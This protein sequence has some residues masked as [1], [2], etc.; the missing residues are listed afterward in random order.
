MFAVLKFQFASNTSVLNLL[1]FFNFLRRAY[2][3]NKWSSIAASRS[4]TN[5]DSIILLIYSS[6]TCLRHSYVV[7]WTG[8]RRW[9]IAGGLCCHVTSQV[10]W[11]E[12]CGAAS[13]YLRGMFTMLPGTCWPACCL[14]RRQHCSSSSSSSRLW[15]SWSY[16]CHR[17]SLWVWSSVDWGVYVFLPPLS[18][19]VQDFLFSLR[20]CLPRHHQPTLCI[21]V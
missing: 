7:C 14:G 16:P 13:M 15:L 12:V 20:S 3:I 1:V 8:S 9:P 21:W 4:Y 6:C 18:F 19:L 2:I 11:T 10:T 17:N 5:N